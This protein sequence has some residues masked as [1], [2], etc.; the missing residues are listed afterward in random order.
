VTTFSTWEAFDESYFRGVT[1]LNSPYPM[2]WPP[3]WCDW[4]EGREL[5]W[6][7]PAGGGVFPRRT[8]L[9]GEPVMLQHEA[10]VWFSC[11]RC[12]PYVNADD[13]E[14]LAV[15]LGLKYPPAWWRAWAA[16]RL[17]AGYAWRWRSAARSA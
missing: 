13:W 9:H 1:P 4:C 10:M 5:A 2:G 12:F 17:S 11:R 6:A 8:S 16:V 3:R 7:T 15:A 14:G